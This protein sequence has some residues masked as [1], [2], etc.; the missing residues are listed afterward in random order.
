MRHGLHI[1]HTTLRPASAL[2]RGGGR[3]GSAGGVRR[4]VRAGTRGDAEV[5]GDGGVRGDA[6]PGAPIGAGHRAT[7]CATHRATHRTRPPADATAEP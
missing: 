3:S 5:R 7:Y 4:R 2:P 6:D 1:A